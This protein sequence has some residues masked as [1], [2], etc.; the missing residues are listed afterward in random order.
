MTLASQ[1]SMNKE[2]YFTAG[3]IQAKSREMLTTLMP[4]RERHGSQALDIHKAALLVLDMQQYFLDPG[5]H[6][7]IPSGPAILPGIRRLVSAFEANGRPVT[8]TRHLN[9][10]ADA[11]LMRKWWRDL[12]REESPLSQLFPG[13]EGAGRKVIRKSQYDAFYNTH[14]EAMLQSE[15]IEQ[16]VI[17]G[18]M[19]HLCCETTARS[20][21][22]RGYEVFVAIDGMATYNRAFHEAALL[23]LS[24]G[25]ASPI[26]V[27]EIIGLIG[28]AR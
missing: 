23:N 25:F 5:S 10:N 27:D 18:V 1:T 26:R 28:E 16:V 2:E 19:T 20:A 11:R 21:F 4:Y 6:A 8:L 3:D 22:M 24:H 9:S 12:I 17:C 7:F 14:L 13:L 15:R